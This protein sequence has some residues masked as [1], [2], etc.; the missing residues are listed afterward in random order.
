MSFREDVNGRISLLVKDMDGSIGLFEVTLT[1][2]SYSST[3]NLLVDLSTRQ[4]TLSDGTPLGQTTIWIQ[5]CKTG[6]RIPFIEQGNST[7]FGEASEIFHMD[8]IQ[9]IQDAIMLDASEHQWKGYVGSYFNISPIETQTI[10]HFKPRGNFYDADTFIMI[11]GIFDED[12]FLSAFGIASFLSEDFK[13]VSTNIDLGPPNLLVAL[14]RSIP[15]IILVAAILVA[16]VYFAFIKKKK[17]RK[18]R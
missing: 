1:I 10:K 4:V 8:T 14:F 7:I 2:G 13:L 9:S 16:I 6:D 15:Y 18:S 12:A 3:K 11:E 5:P 17:G